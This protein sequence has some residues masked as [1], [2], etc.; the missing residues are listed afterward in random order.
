MS[1]GNNFNNSI[2]S[3]GNNFNNTINIGLNKLTKAGSYDVNQQSINPLL[4][5]VGLNQVDN[6]INSLNNLF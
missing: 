4:N 6:K 5:N 2:N 1:L 3:I